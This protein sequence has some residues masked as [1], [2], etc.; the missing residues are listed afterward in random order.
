[1]VCVCVCVPDVPDPLPCLLHQAT[2][3]PTA[4]PGCLTTQPPAHL[5]H[6]AHDVPGALCRLL[7]SSPHCRHHPLAD[8]LRVLRAVRFASRFGFE[9]EPTLLEA[10]SDPEVHDHLKWKVSRE[11]IGT[12][13]EGML[14][15]ELA[16][17]CC[18]GWGSSEACQ[19]AGLGLGCHCRS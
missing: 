1:M 17:L 13:F 8:P 18:A 10:A 12:E 14:H 11:R 19:A 15:G 7:I 5:R 3:C 9:L 16:E 2:I 4:L 6:A